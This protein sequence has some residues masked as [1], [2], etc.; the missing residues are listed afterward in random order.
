MRKKQTPSSPLPQIGVIIGTVIL[1]YM[2][3]VWVFGLPISLFPPSPQTND[4]LT[5]TGHASVGSGTCD[6]DMY[7]PVCARDGTE[8]RNAC[9]AMRAQATIAFS[10]SCQDM[11]KDHDHSLNILS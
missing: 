2:V 5:A 6:L 1:I 9:F 3:A 11:K 8:Y 7:S 4:P 10:G